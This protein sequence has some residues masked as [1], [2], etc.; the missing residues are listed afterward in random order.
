M[1]ALGNL[2][3]E[4]LKPEVQSSDEQSTAD[5]PGLNEDEDV[6]FVTTCDPLSF[7]VVIGVRST[8]KYCSDS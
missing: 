6:T 7:E 5:D 4:G 3:L 2:K 1:L 8:V